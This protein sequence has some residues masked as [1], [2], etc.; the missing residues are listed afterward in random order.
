MFAIPARLRR[1]QIEI[2]TGCN[3]RCVG[4]Q[5]TIG[6]QAKAWRNTHMRPRRFAAVIDH[7]PPAD[8]VI[9][10]GIGEP[11]LHPGLGGLIETAR[12]S[13]KFRAIS[14]NTNALFL[15]TEA[16]RDL[17]AK[18]LNHISI[19]IDS[20]EPETAEALR[21]GTDCDRLKTATA[22][23]IAL[24]EGQ[25]TLSTVLSRK[26]LPELEDLIGQIYGLGGRLIEIQPL[27]SYDQALD[28][29]A[30]GPSDQVRARTIIEAARQRLPGLTLW[31][32]PALTPSGTRCRRP[33]TAAYVTVDG[34]LTPCCT[35]NDVA[36][37][38]RTSLADLPWDQAW[39]QPGVQQWLQGFFDRD[40]AICAGCA[41]N[42]AGAGAVTTAATLDPSEA[43]R[44]HLAGELDAAEKAFE[45]LLVAGAAAEA[46]Q[47]LGLIR[48][49]RGDP[50][51]ALPLMQS[52]H[53]LA[54][55][56]RTAFNLAQVYLALGRTAEA[57]ALHRDNV[58]RHP[59]YAQSYPAL[60]ELAAGQGDRT[61][62]ASVLA[63]LATRAI[64][65]ANRGVLDRAVG[66]LLRLDVDPPAVTLL[67][68]R[69]RLAGR[70]DLAVRVLEAR[71]GRAPGDLGARLALAMAR[72]AV[73]HAS[74]AE[75]A[76]RRNAY[77]RD[78]AAVETALDLA[79][80]AA[81]AHEAEEI[82]AAKPFLLAYQGQDD[83][84]LQAT[85]GRIAARM[86]AAAD[87]DRPR[88]AGSAGSARTSDRLRIGFAT[89][90]FHQ[91]SVSK[92]FGG[93]IE[94]LDRSRFEVFGYHL[95]EGEDAVSARLAAACDAF[96]RGPA[97]HRRWAE[98]IA[99][100]NL[101]VLIYPEIGMH[102]IPV[103][104]ACRR[105]APVQCVAWGHPVTTGL[106]DI[107]WFLSSDL[108][109]P[110]DGAR[111]YTER[112]LRLPNLSIW[113]EPLPTEGGAVT[114]A[115]LGLAEDDV[116]YVCCQSLFKYLPRWDWVFPAIAARV[117]SA[118][119]LF[120][121]DSREGVTAAFRQR[122]AGAFAA[123]GLDPDHHLVF[124]AAVPQEDF[125]S[126]L[127]AGD[128]YLDSIG[129][130][131]GNTTLEAV[132]CDLPVVTWPTELMRARHTLAIL[133]RMGL[134]DLIAD[135]PER[136]VDLAVSLADPAGRAAVS[137]EVALRKTRLY[138][139]PAP[140]R[141]LEAFLQAATAEARGATP[142]DAFARRIGASS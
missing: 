116:V 115:G 5:R 137:A 11:T 7:A 39:T 109:E 104:L 69:L 86:M 46:L 2:T 75:I 142:V 98:V 17:K 77:G 70:D 131:G 136:Y 119:F 123:A 121:R 84:S 58:E 60:A 124:A 59:D 73:I 89:A 66:G 41:F 107:D 118:R 10:Q 61:G 95:G 94:Q 16:Y 93:W 13:G 117:A 90:Y 20:L 91:H 132:A 99:G 37:W 120:I 128:L 79:D 43:R 64:A 1:L 51:A 114:R 23:L 139:D 53:T 112:L 85:Y 50:A 129:W 52:A 65:A 81:I 67:A 62:A 33:F 19:S 100:D 34:L 78:L 56:P 44:L 74:E 27:I 126:L 55:E 135:T 4:C 122:L 133:T 97:G 125:S 101:D 18:G 57:I 47:G 30:L 102:P 21:A 141:A 71:L 32:A 103:Q 12:A 8:T 22:E 76:E 48:H 108:M 15:E 96:R 45:S 54:P 113:Y 80:P 31:P 24:F 36:L 26:N 111:R 140:I 68:N 88:S 106:P 25:V 6:M 40:D 72:L 42:P 87:G 134:D 29:L 49:Q 83:R 92:L 82:G 38:G 9:L 138:H 105:L 28:S 3:L 127:R 110:P 35:T 130:S 14:F 63:A